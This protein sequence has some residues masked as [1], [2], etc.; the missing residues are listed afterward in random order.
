MQDKGQCGA[1]HRLWAATGRKRCV[2]P[3]LT[4]VCP[5]RMEKRS[6][7]TGCSSTAALLLECYRALPPSC[8]DERIDGFHT[9]GRFS[10]R[11]RPRVAVWNLE[12]WRSLVCYEALAIARR[13]Q[14]LWRCQK[15]AFAS[16]NICAQF[17]RARGL[18]ASRSA[19]ET[20]G[21]KTLSYI[22]RDFPR[23]MSRAVRCRFDSV[24]DICCN[25][26]NAI[27]CEM[28]LWLGLPFS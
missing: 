27:L 24:E 8:D 5:M 22:C 21:I 6:G 12:G 25:S 11:Q 17:L 16:F 19:I 3:P 1:S 26:Y 10:S 13:V 23:I 14:L 7:S 2:R 4:S 20:V 28:D 15:G 9:F 18:D